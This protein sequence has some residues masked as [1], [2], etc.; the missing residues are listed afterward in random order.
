[1][2]EAERAGEVGLQGAGAIAACDV[3]GDAVE[4]QFAD[5]IGCVGEAAVTLAD[6]HLVAGF[7]QLALQGKDAEA[8]G[9]ALAFVEIGRIEIDRVETILSKIGKFRLLARIVRDLV[10]V[11]GDAKQEAQAGVVVDQVTDV[12][13]ALRLVGVVVDRL[14]AG[15]RILDAGVVRQVVAG[16]EPAPAYGIA[17]HR[18]VRVERGVAAAGDAHAAAVAEVA[19]VLGG[20][21][22][23]GCGAQPV[24]RRECA[25]QQLHV[26]DDA[27]VEALAEAT[28]GLGDDHA[29]DAVLQ[30]AMVAAYVQATV[31]ILHY[32]RGL[33]QHLVDRRGRAQRQSR[34][35]LVV[36]HVLAGTGVRRQRI[37]R[38]VQGGG[39][40]DDTQFLY[41]GREVART[42]GLVVGIGGWRGR[43]GDRVLGVRGGRGQ[44]GDE[45]EG[46][47]RK[48]HAG[49]RRPW[50]RASVYY[51][52]S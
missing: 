17:P 28:D 39:H 5:V 49:V 48:F 4:H 15:R 6:G 24:L 37:A 27:R 50:R 1:V 31:R 23:H 42:R 11:V 22:H 8:G 41:L 30:V 40:R 47:R 18:R 29:V 34:N 32:A 7:A 33:Q 14:P 38:L 26:A 45:A 19:A 44:G 13:E 10:V 51:V 35:R 3:R 2:V 12:A 46:K 25:V 52:I 20:D 21:I 43:R 36:D 16:E 9:L